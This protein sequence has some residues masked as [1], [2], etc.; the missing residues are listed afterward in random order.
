MFHYITDL[1]SLEH[2][3]QQDFYNAGIFI[4]NNSE[5]ND[6]I[7]V[8]GLRPQ[9]YLYAER[10]SVSNCYLTVNCPDIDFL[11]LKPIYIVARGEKNYE[12]YNVKYRSGEIYLYGK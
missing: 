7:Y 4:K 1:Y 5:I 9:V 12:G 3:S 6:K 11:S 2:S 10:E 8:D